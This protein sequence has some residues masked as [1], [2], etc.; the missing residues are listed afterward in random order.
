M[1]AIIFTTLA[2]LA[3]FGATPA[4]AQ[5]SCVG[6]AAP[7]ELGQNG[8][9]AFNIRSGDSCMYGFELGGVVNSSRVLQRPAHGTLT[10]IN[11][12]TL[13]YDAAPGYR[14]RD[15]FIIEATGVSRKGRRGTSRIDVRVGI[16]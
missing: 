9:A 13:K 1:K 7:M 5:V 2:G 11:L 15:R 6:S 3:L 4:P 8:T 10:G 12:T 16:Q 14:G